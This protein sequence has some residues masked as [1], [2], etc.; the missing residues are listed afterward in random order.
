MSQYQ[1]IPLLRTAQTEFIGDSEIRWCALFKRTSPRKS[2]YHGLTSFYFVQWMSDNRHISPLGLRRVRFERVP[3]SSLIIRSRSLPSNFTSI[4]IFVVQI[5]HR[6]E[7]FTLDRSQDPFAHV[8][9]RYDSEC[10]SQSPR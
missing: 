10:R 8:T 1:L 9:N 2:V 7:A 4:G 3:L 6:S 5:E